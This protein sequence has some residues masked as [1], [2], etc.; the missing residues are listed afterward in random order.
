M[1]IKIF[2]NIGAVKITLDAFWKLQKVNKFVTSDNL[3]CN[4][5]YLSAQVSKEDTNAL[6]AA[7]S[8]VLE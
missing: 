2:N 5:G 7:S 8:V 1:L 4:R 3:P 6:V